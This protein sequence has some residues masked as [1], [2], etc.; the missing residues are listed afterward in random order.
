MARAVVSTAVLG[1]TQFTSQANPVLM[2][3]S[4]ICNGTRGL[5]EMN[6][7]IQTPGDEAR[8]SYHHML[9]NDVNA[10]L[11]RWGII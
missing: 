2:P 10:T 8:V 1:F 6:I 11:H 5:N 9:E 7:L 4:H 3:D